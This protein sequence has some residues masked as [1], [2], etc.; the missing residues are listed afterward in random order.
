MHSNKRLERFRV[1]RE[2]LAKIKA[3]H[4]NAVKLRVGFNERA[5][6]GVLDFYVANGKVFMI[7]WFGHDGIDGWEIWHPA[8]SDELAQSSFQAAEKYLGLSDESGNR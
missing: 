1:V 2:W 4:V 3:E 8:S 6:G 5:S 7:Q